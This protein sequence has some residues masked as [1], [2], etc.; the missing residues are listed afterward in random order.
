MTRKEDCVKED[1]SPKTNEPQAAMA[2]EKD[3]PLCK[4]H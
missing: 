4:G 1:T 3:T 2:V